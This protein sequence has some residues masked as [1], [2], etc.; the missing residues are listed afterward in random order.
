MVRLRS[1][2]YLVL[3][4][5]TLARAAPIA[6]TVIDGE[7]LAPI[8]GA[9]ITSGATT[10]RSADDG[11]FVVET[12]EVTVSAPGYEPTTERLGE[13]ATIVLFHTG[14]LAETVEIVDRAPRAGASDA[15]LLTR[16]EI[17]NQ[18][19]GGAD[20]LAAVRS[21][22]G[23]GSA[24]P[25]AG[26]RLVIRGA[27][28]EDSLLTIDGVPVPFLYHSFNN[29]TILP[30]SMIGA[31]AYAPG[32]F[33]AD[34]GRATGGVVAITTDDTPVT[35]PTGEASASFTE[36]YAHLAVPLSSRVSVQGGLR[37]S[38]VDLL[39][40]VAV[41]DDLMVGFTTPPR[42]YDAQL[43][44]DAHATTRDR[45]AILGL[46]SYDRIGIVNRDPISE[47]PAEVSAT[48]R[49]GRVIASWKH[50]GSRVDHRLVA[51][52]G[53][54]RWD[55]D[56]GPEQE[57][58]ARHAMAMLRHDTT[59]TIT[60]RIAVRAGGLAGLDD[61][62]IHSRTFLLPSEGLPPE[63]LDDLPIRTIDARY[64]AN[65]AAAYA[66]TDLRITD[67]TTAS[68][69]VRVEYYNHLRTTRVLPRVQLAWARGPVSLHGALGIYARDLDQAEGIAT[70]LRPETAMQATTSAEVV[71]TDGVT[72]A[73]SAFATARRDLVIEDPETL[74]LPYRS[75]AHGRSRGGELMLRAVRGESFAWLAYTYTRS[76]RD[77]GE[78]TVIRPTASDQPHV[79]TAVASTRRGA[80]RFGARWQLASG[81]PYTEVVGATYVP[82]VDRYVPTLGAAFAARYPTSHQ[83]DVRVERT[84][85]RK[86]Y[87]IVGFLDVA[88]TYRNARVVRYQY[89][90]TYATK[91]PIDDMIPLPSL[92]VRAEL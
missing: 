68:P 1:F 19:G 42:F 60:D 47:L 38:T 72:L 11:T 16:D 73:G 56:L 24:P 9:T 18:P 49:F 58:H 85:Q 87:R 53:A 29:T 30:V 55:T 14:A 65:T 61:N 13:A 8:A 36:A 37:R 23:I 51:A 32:G 40:P 21:M 78:M 84:W 63:R 82:D 39:A 69:G 48:G 20:G 74:D 33:G 10:T 57:L 79:V 35:R 4:I 12:P 27:S 52:L 2:A 62:E 90:P 17:Q 31:I 67:H 28:P 92:G 81:L 59:A 75:G 76:K 7:T 46:A 43:R 70:T 5:P 3:C 15:R 6:A 26:G 54:D 44:L 91:Q 77:D 64:D 66:A 88:N 45:F 86:G 41:P 83:L 34:E 71:L 22:P 80:W 89:D 25:T 50:D